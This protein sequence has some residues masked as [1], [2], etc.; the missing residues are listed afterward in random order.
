MAAR[1]QE[2]YKNTVVPELVKKFG[3][4]SVMEV[5][6]IEKIVVNMGLGEAIQNVKI[7][8]SAAAELSAITGTSCRNCTYGSIFRF[9]RSEIL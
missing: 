4:K 7:L 8:D 3:Y 5:P 2:F 1:L 9:M 6:R